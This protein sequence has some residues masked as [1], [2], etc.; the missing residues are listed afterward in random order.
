MVIGKKQK[1]KEIYKVLKMYCQGGEK[2]WGEGK[3]AMKMSLF[4]YEKLYIIC[5]LHKSFK[6]IEAKYLI[7]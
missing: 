5:R 7:N 3:R 2:R 4:S 1:T 6:K